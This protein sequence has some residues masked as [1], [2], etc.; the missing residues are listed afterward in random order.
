MA[1]Q[2]KDMQQNVE[3]K[4]FFVLNKITRIIFVSIVE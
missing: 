2:K 1:S 3:V 4:T